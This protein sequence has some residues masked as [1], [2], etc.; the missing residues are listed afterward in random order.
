MS[1]KYNDT[2]YTMVYNGQIYNKEEI[3][4]DLQDLGYSFKRIF[5][6]RSFA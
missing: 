5:W 3:K 6:Y 2:T 1:V 4:K